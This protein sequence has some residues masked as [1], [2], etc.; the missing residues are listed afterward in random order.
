M[1]LLYYLF[2]ILIFGSIY[3]RL[4]EG[5]VYYVKPVKHLIS[6]PGN[7]SCPP[8]QLCHTM[9]YLAEYSSEFF[10]PDH[11]NVANTDIHVWSPQLYKK[12]DSTKSSLIYHERNCRIQ[13]ECHS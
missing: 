6:C 1:R 10:S 5:K 4:T 7:T 9:D 13:R 2:F 3:I 11:I 12:L 8:G